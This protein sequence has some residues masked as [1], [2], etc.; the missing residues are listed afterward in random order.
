ML[1]VKEI[2]HEAVHIADITNAQFS[3]TFK[4]ILP[5]AAPPRIRLTLYLVHPGSF[6][7]YQPIY[8]DRRDYI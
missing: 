2:L 6:R 3:H 5:C 7:T 8:I 4:L 1:P